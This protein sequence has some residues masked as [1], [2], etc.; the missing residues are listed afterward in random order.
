MLLKRSADLPFNQ[1]VD[2]RER[3]PSSA[4]STH[5][6]QQ[7]RTANDRAHAGTVTTVRSSDRRGFSSVREADAMRALD[8]DDAGAPRPG[9]LLGGKYVVERVLGV[10]GMAAVVSARHAQI[11]QRVAIKYLLPAAASMPQ[12]AERF[13]REARAA[14]RVCGTHVVRVLD[15]GTF[16]DG[17]PYMVLE[18]LEGVDLE[19]FALEHG[20]LPVRQAVGFVL[21]ACV[22]IAEAHRAGI[23]HRD[24]KPSNLFLA[25]QPD[26]RSIVK[27]LD[28]G[29]S[30]VCNEP[31]A[32]L[33]ATREL[34]G[35]PYYM[36]P[37]QLLSS[38]DVDAR[39]DIWALGVVLY[40][41]LTGCI[42][43]GGET[44]PEIIAGVLHNV[45]APLETLRADIP[46]S[47]CSVIGRCLRSKPAERYENIADLA[48][49]LAPHA[50]AR[51]A[52]LGDAVER[53]LSD[54][55]RPPRGTLAEQPRALERHLRSGQEPLATDTRPSSLLAT[56]SPAY[57]VHGEGARGTFRGLSPGT[58]DVELPKP[59]AAW[60]TIAS[61]VVG[62]AV[63]AVAARAVLLHR[64]TSASGLGAALVA[65][66]EASS[67]PAV[68]D[69]RQPSAA[70]KAQESSASPSSAAAPPPRARR[71][72]RTRAPA[73]GRP[74][75]HALTQA[76]S[77]DAGAPSPAL[78]LS[79]STVGTQ[80]DGALPLGASTPPSLIAASPP[81]DPA[82][83]PP[84]PADGVSPTPAGVDPLP[85]DLPPAA[86]A[87][88]GQALAPV[89]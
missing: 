81:A 2:P 57:V 64:A 16:D 44:L 20:L 55:V 43:F 87:V 32:S 84:P 22:G 5:G 74:I 72:P 62:V 56:L 7:T 37:E 29:I 49:A 3:D 51:D 59:P 77:D 21:E 67:V 24:I 75:A 8:T 6:N 35:T 60:R 18:H 11:D 15:V 79:T 23:V 45:P 38:K 68:A 76:S 53:V 27:V 86:A 28:F 46:S 25:R 4:F 39:A 58:S 71:Q 66:G 50:S 83:P 31:N 82:P 26:K 9:M 54:S 13:V 30:K 36:S 88:S 17:A 69:L 63:L 41:L 12:A 10:G 70:P 19:Q 40:Q 89:K 48:R 73:D 1:T 34:L 78:S 42:P 80:P 14:A 85:V 47:L 33:T 61:I 52:E 65:S